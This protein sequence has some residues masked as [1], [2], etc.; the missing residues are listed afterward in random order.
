MGRKP[1]SSQTK[2][3]V[4]AARRQVEEAERQEFTEG[5]IT[6][7]NG[8]VLH[9]KAVP[10]AMVRRVATKIEKPK[11]P[12]ADLGKGREEDNPGDPTY[13]DEV[14]Q[15]HFVVGEATVNVILSMGVSVVSVPEGM[16]KIEDEE[17][18]EALEY[19]EVD[20]EYDLNTKIGRKLAWL[21]YYAIQGETEWLKV[22]GKISAMIGMT[23]GEVAQAIDSFRSG[24]ARRGNNGV[25][26]EDAEHRD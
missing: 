22:L 24:E 4:A 23:E 5:D 19:F 2:E 16:S 21:S 17:W 25:P 15:Y 13:L 9:L 1:G 8:I 3:A 18:T 11:V 12:K 6:L 14:D 10:A 7:S 20:E 26:A